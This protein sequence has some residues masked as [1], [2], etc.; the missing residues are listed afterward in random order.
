MEEQVVEGK[1]KHLLCLLGVPIAYPRL[2]WLENMMQSPH[3]VRPLRYISKMTGGLSSVFNDFDGAVELLDD[4]QDHWA[5]GLHKKERA[6]LIL[7]LQE[8][9]KRKQVRITILSDV[10]LAA[11]GS[12]SAITNAP[13]PAAVA[14]ILHNR[15]K[16]HHLD[17]S[18]DENLMRMWNVSASDNSTRI[19]ETTYPA[20]N[21][22]TIQLQKE[23]GDHPFAPQ[24]GEGGDGVA[25]RGV[26]AKKVRGSA[27]DEGLTITIQV[28]V[29]GKSASGETKAYAFSIPA[30][31]L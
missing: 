18:T 31:S 4:L 17:K 19:N 28:E 1:T 25:K 14:M 20:R 3:L 16:T 12:S 6:H 5:C 7:R 23:G 22:C 13:P 30:L 29:D 21:F 27:V 15:N 26:R 24:Q 9:A 10:H 8:F 2:V 11:V